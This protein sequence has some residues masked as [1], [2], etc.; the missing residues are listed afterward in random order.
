M[1]RPLWFVTILKKSFPSRFRLARLTK[2]PI[3]GN[4]VDYMLFDGDSIIYLP[5]DTAVQPNQPTHK[6]VVGRVV[7]QINQ[8]VEPRTD[9]VLPSSVVEYFIERTNYIWLMNFCICRL[10][11][12]CTDYPIELG[13]IFLGEAVLKINPKLGR[14]ATKEEA[15]E[16]LQRCHDAGLV[17]LV[18]RNKLDTVWLGAT[19][20]ERL[21][22][23]CNCCPCCCLWKMIP[24]LDISI[25]KKVTR[26]PGVHVTVTDNCIGCGICAKETVCFVGAIQMEDKRAV[27]SDACRGCCRCIESCP[28]SIRAIELTID[29]SQFI[30]NAINRISHLVDIS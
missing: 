4:L 27:I 2:L 9:I 11:E 15:F 8:P 22:T 5:K 7:I 16:H 28:E 19:P 29:D 14:L 12:Q 6:S 10:S 13:C 17:H 3:I 30:N 26:M 24:N 20:G 1:A 25:S 21:L 18:G 23:I